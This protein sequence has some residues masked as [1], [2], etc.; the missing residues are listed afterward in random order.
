MRVGVDGKPLLPPRAG[1]AR[2]LEGLLGACAADL[3]HTGIEIAVISPRRPRR[4]MPWVLWDLQRSTGRGFDVFHFPFY[5]PPSGRGVR[6]RLRSTTSWSSSTRVVPGGGPTRSG[7][8]SRPAPVA[9]MQS[10][11]FAER[12]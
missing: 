5:Y 9:P 8:S 7:C 6:S 4:T 1:V 2:Y 3:E 12:G 11:R 10:H